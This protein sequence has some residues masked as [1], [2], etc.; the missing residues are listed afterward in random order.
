MQQAG[1]LAV[2]A[3]DTSL[4]DAQSPPNGSRMKVLRLSAQQKRRI[5]IPVVVIS[6]EDG[7]GLLT[8]L[9]S[10]SDVEVRINLAGQC[11]YFHFE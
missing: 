10:K 1:V 5:T 3:I 6:K 4:R 7:V 8:L 9:K 11:T 2:I